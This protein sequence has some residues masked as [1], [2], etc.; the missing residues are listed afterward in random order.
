MSK[1]YT[2]SDHIKFYIVFVLRIKVFSVIANFKG[3]IILNI[4]HLQFRTEFIF[5]SS[6]KSR[7]CLG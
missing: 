1:I 2:I 5:E 6:G 3:K 7:I 4:I